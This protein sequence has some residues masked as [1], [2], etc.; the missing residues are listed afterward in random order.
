MSRKRLLAAWVI[1]TVLLLAVTAFGQTTASIKGTVTDTTG[2]AVVGA[3][4]TVKGPL[5]IERTAQ[6]NETGDYSVPALPP[7]VYSVE[8]QMKGFQAQQAKDVVLEVSKNSV[9]NFS[10]KV[11]TAS[12]VITVE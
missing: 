4:V 10:M 3:K 12:E 9:Q 11:A 8:I 5:G 2:A 7:G 1:S 6:T